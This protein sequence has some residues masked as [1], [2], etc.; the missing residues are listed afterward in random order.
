MCASAANVLCSDAEVLGTKL[1]LL[2]IFY[3]KPFLIIEVLIY[4]EWMYTYL[5]SGF[6]MVGV[7]ALIELLLLA[8]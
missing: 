5:F 6:I 4:S 1:F 2:I 8:K 3:N 7:I